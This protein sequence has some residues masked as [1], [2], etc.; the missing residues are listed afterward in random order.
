[1]YCVQYSGIAH[2]SCL[3]TPVPCTQYLRTVPGNLY[4]VPCNNSYWNQAECEITAIGQ[5]MG[6][7]CPIVHVI[8]HSVRTFLPSSHS[9]FELASCSILAPNYG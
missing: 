7:G 5:F 2:G 9:V 1:M 6:K 8:G 4:P 3:S